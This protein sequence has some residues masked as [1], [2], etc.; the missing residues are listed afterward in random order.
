MYKA[1]SEI[2]KKR[3]LI[4]AFQRKGIAELLTEELF[5]LAIEI[6]WNFNCENWNK[7]ISRR[8]DNKVEDPEMRIWGMMGSLNGADWLDTTRL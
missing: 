5:S 2:K 6:R 3:R 7:R 8:G 4:W 1:L